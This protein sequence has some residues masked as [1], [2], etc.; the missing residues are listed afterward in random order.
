MAARRLAA[1]SAVHKAFGINDPTAS[2]KVKTATTSTR[3]T[4]VTEGPDSAGTSDTDAT[5]IAPDG[6]QPAPDVPERIGK[7]HIK[8]V[9]ASGG[10]GT[11]YEAVQ[12]QPRRHVA[13][14]VMKQGIT[15]R[16]ALRRFE[17]ESQLL[18]RLRHPNVAQVYEAGTHDDGHPHSSCR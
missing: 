6:G 7:Y 12:E 15:S 2:V 3:S 9:I 18:A 8:R 17:F 13:L 1:L 14:K 11:V 16:S 5:K 10:M 4:Q